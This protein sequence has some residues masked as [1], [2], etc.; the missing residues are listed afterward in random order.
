M[1]SES[2]KRNRALTLR[3]NSTTNR[4]FSPFLEG[5]RSARKL[6]PDQVPAQPACRMLYSMGDGSTNDEIPS[7]GCQGIHG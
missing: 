7:V 4:F 1:P 5:L 2:T 6:L 3:P